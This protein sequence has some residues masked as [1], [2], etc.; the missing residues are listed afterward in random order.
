M[1][2]PEEIAKGRAKSIES[3]ATDR[4]A[5]PAL[6]IRMVMIVLSLGQL[7]EIIPH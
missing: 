2:A 5:K 1:I 6:E 3:S 4:R 7:R